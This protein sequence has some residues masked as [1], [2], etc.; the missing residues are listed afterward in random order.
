MLHTHPSVSTLQSCFLLQ[1]MAFC[2]QQVISNCVARTSFKVALFYYVI[3]CTLCTF[4]Q[5]GFKSNCYNWLL[6]I[7][8]ICWLQRISLKNYFLNT[9]FGCAREKLLSIMFI[10]KQGT[11]QLLGV[12]KRKFLVFQ[13]M[14]ILSFALVVGPKSNT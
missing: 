12:L 1:S 8:R 7:N 4:S 13:E 3:V 5:S 2:Y 9:E 14:V 10:C 11:T 6:V